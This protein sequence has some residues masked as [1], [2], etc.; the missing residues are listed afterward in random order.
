MDGHPTSGHTTRQEQIIED[1][2]DVWLENDQRQ[3]DYNIHRR[4]ASNCKKFIKY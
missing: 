1:H 2:Y 4:L 3:A